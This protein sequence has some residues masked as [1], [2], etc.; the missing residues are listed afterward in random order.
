MI[1]FASAQ[2]ALIAAAA[3]IAPGAFLLIALV[4]GAAPFAALYALELIVD[5]AQGKTT[6]IVIAT[7]TYAT[8][9]FAAIATTN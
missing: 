5:H 4:I 1:A 3:Q 2:C 6:A 7:M 8:I 9:C